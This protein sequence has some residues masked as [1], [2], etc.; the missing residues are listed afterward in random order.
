MYAK[1]RLKDLSANKLVERDHIIE[2]NESLSD[3]DSGTRSE[4]NS[5]EESNDSSIDDNEKVVNIEK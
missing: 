2:D 1:D 3:Y 4:M 5:I